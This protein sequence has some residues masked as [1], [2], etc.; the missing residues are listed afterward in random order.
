MNSFTKI[1]GRIKN[2][3]YLTAVLI[4]TIIL[5]TYFQSCEQDFVSN[6]T[7]VQGFP[8]EI[9]AI[10]NAPLNANNVTCTTPSCHASENS[11]SGM[12]LVDWQ[13]AMNGSNNGTMIVA[14]NGF[15]S[16]LISTVNSDTNYAPVSNV[17]LPEFHKI[18]SGKVATLMAWINDGA[19][20]KDGNVAFTNI[21]NSDKG[22]ITNQAADLVAVIQP[23]ERR[24]V[25]LV[26]VGGRSSILDAPHY[27][28]ISP[29]KR[30]FYVS[31]IQ[32]G[33]VEKY[34]ASTY[35][36]VGRMA[37]GQS[38]AHIEIS[39]DGS[40]GFVTNFESSG[41][42]R[43]TTKFNTESMSIT[44]IYNDAAMTGPHGMALTQNGNT[45][46]VTSEIGEYI[47]KISTSAFSSDSSMKAPIDASVPPNG[48]GTSHFRPY[49]VVLSRDESLIYVACRGSNQ[50]RI[51]NTSDLAQVNAIDLGTNAF[52]LLMKL[53]NDGNYLFVCNRNN[54]T[55][56]IINCNTQTLVTTVTGVG[57]Q[58]HGVDFT[59]DG[60]YAI[61]AC[62]TQS[63]FDGHHP[64]VG[65][66]K[67]GV[68]RVI[69]VSNFSLLPDRMEMASFPAGIE[70]MK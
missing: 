57:V 9:E 42:V 50:V 66:T 51:Y 40:T 60:Q 24:T 17:S 41:A 16:H 20:S 64:Q 58:P 63:G 38:P 48:Q 11:A 19:K 26:P 25:R 56:S 45:L 5:F 21:S 59:A 22:F 27:V 35:A 34:D 67:I 14:Y 23:N 18:D 68:T 43:T 31:L 33:F 55:V 30:Y 69:Q 10:F 62:E 3:F 8:S 28:K 7:S 52:P 61:I 37:A 49:Q 65:S 6:P 54:N 39:P 47:F 70:I 4:C 32:E 12:N 2:V 46:F 36:L 29:D 53:T 44:G 1:S 15:W 13:K